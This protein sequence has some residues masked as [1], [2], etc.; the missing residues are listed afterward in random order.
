MPTQ[1]EEKQ[2]VPQYYQNEGGEEESATRLFTPETLPTKKNNQI[3]Q[4]GK[5]PQNGNTEE[6]FTLSES[7]I[8]DSFMN[9]AKAVVRKRYLLYRNS[10][11]YIFFDIFLPVLFMIAGIW[12]TT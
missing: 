1:N 5:R 12:V 11:R 10:K 9:S 6:I 4:G 7:K 3:V 2:Y 8:D